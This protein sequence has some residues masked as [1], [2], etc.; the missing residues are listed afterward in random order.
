MRECLCGC[1]KMVEG[2]RRQAVYATEV[3]AKRV[4]NRRRDNRALRLRSKY[5]L[6]TEQ[7]VEMAVRQGGK[8]AVCRTAILTDVDHDHSTGYVRGLV[9]NPCNRL[10][11]ALEISGRYV[12]EAQEYLDQP[13]SPY[14]PAPF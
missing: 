14:P 5:G 12:K 11:A 9:C 2:R 10:L 1:G 8:C 3:C 7:F 6:T 4:Q 13:R